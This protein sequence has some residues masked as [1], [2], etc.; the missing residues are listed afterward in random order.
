MSELRDTI[1][2]VDDEPQNL[3]LLGGILR[4]EHEVII[5]TSGRE[6]IR[7]VCSETSPDLILLDIVMPDMDGLD[8]CRELKANPATE[9]IPIIF[10][11]ARDKV[12]DEAEGF[13]VGAVDYIAKP[14]SADIVR[15]RVRTHLTLK[16]QADKLASL[17]VI[18]ELTGLPN[19]RR[20]NQRLED[21]WKRAV[22]SGKALTLVMIDVDHFKRYNDNYGHSAGDDCLRYVAR[23]LDKVVQRAADMVA[24]YGGE[25]FVAILPDTNAI[26]GLQV[27][28]RFCD[29]ISALQLEHKYSP[30]GKHITISVGVATCIPTMHIRS[31]TLLEMADNMLY[32]AKRK[33]RNCVVTNQ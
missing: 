33:G 31:Q 24:R 30:S 2:I 28:E 11:T 20:F 8:V 5:A 21:E 15:A 7:R 9:G 1:L 12:A 10:I 22:R 6:A 4:E 17:T 23:A 16:R 29:T 14:F 27:G 13:A 26:Q 32:K 19:R 18:D 3:H 25:E